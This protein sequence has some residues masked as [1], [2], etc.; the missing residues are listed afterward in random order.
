[1]ARHS[2]IW[3]VQERAIVQMELHATLKQALVQTLNVLLDGQA[4]QHV[5]TVSTQNLK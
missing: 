3:T 1:V 2:G 5:A 4:L